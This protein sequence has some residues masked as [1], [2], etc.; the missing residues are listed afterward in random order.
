MIKKAEKAKRFLKNYNDRQRRISSNKGQSDD[1][2]EDS[3]YDSRND[4]VKASSSKA[5]TISCEIPDDAEDS[6]TSSSDDGYEEGEERSPGRR[7]RKN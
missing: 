4:D 5:Y 3:S 6:P 2:R 1:N 7:R